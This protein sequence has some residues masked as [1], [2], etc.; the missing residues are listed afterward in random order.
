MLKPSCSSVPLLILNHSQY[1]TMSNH[2]LGI[3][4]D[5]SAWD[6]APHCSLP[7]ES[8]KTKWENIKIYHGDNFVFIDRYRNSNTQ[9]NS[10]DI[11]HQKAQIQAFDQLDVSRILSVHSVRTLTRNMPPGTLMIPDDFF[12][13]W[14]SVSFQVNT[15]PGQVASLDDDFR[16][17]IRE[18]L[19]EGNIRFQEGGTYLQITGP[20]Y[21]SPSEATF[22]AQ[23]AEILGMRAASELILANQKEIPFGIL[24]SIEHYANGI[25]NTELSRSSFQQK[26]EMNAPGLRRATKAIIQQIN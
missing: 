15:P 22:F 7:R 13:P 25:E 19:I 11:L 24:C 8:I 1:A 18:A 2:N 23:A 14:H 16:K 20:R 4:A 12:Y 21:E 3:L 9:N 26:K 6:D 5:S 17:Q 10:K